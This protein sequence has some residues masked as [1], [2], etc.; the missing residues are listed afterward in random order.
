MVFVFSFRCF[1]ANRPPCARADERS[2]RGAPRE[3]NGSQ[4]AWRQT[5]YARDEDVKGADDAL[6]DCAVHFSGGGSEVTLLTD[7]KTL[8]LKAMFHAVKSISITE[9]L[10]GLEGG[11][12]AVL[13]KSID[14]EVAIH[15]LRNY[16][17]K[18]RRADNPRSVSSNG[19]GLD[20]SVD[21]GPNVSLVK[22]AV[23][24]GQ[25][26]H[27]VASG[28]VRKT[29][30]RTVAG[31]RR[32]DKYGK[33]IKSPTLPA[34]RT[35][36]SDGARQ[37]G[38]RTRGGRS[39][40]VRGRAT[41]SGRRGDEL[42]KKEEESLSEAEERRT[43]GGSTRNKTQRR[44]PRFAQTEGGKKE[45][46]GGADLLGL[47]NR[48]NAQAVDAGEKTTSSRPGRSRGTEMRRQQPP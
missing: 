14:T 12:S 2:G 30:V 42:Y 5:T 37:E 39:K 38:R 29:S 22:V 16:E 28:T 25:E 35:D 7:D 36:E 1:L 15:Q 8:Q 43:T 3:R 19:T 45:E 33:L 10:G 18:T 26:A 44:R 46:R 4:G 27:L 48:L 17:S 40:T 24:V 41:T 11:K 34:V 31:L 32:S 23:D 13:P 20:E 9:F 21:A 6:L 47:A